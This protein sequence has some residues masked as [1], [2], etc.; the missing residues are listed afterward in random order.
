ME[1][2]TE[3]WVRWRYQR[4]LPLAG[5]S[6]IAGSAYAA[7]VAA[8]ELR[9]NARRR[10]VAV[11]R[12]ARWSSGGDQRLARA[13]YHRSLLSEA[14]EEADSARFM[15]DPAAL[16]RWLPE[17]VARC[18]GGPIVLASLHL[19]S[20][21]LG[22]VALQRRCALDVRAMV[23]GLD[24]ANPM[25]D[26]KRRWGSRKVAWVR[27]VTAGGVLG[28]DAAAVGAARDHLLAG[29]A[30]F[31]ALD[32][33]GDVVS[34]SATVTMHGERLLFSSGV[35]RLAALTRSTIVPLVAVGG[36]R[37]RLHYGTPIRAFDHPDPV[38][39]IFAELGGLIDRF[40]GEWWMW[41]FLQTAT[42]QPA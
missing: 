41:P 26:P 31:A 20:P 28:A 25:R 5:S 3:S 19:G 16:G 1:S 24:D 34:R 30:I 12:I 2:T 13:I 38:A 33:P 29:Q 17:E 37:L 4:L 7:L 40:P 35:V 11:Q 36:A 23:R 27:D 39:A 32:V 8:V 14:R 9:R 15:H 6:V 21:V 18:V 42:E 22:F 10:A